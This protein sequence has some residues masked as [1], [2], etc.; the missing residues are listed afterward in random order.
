ME[1]AAAG[2]KPG[3]TRSVRWPA[4][5]TAWRVSEGDHVQMGQTLAQVRILGEAIDVPA[6]HAGLIELILVPA[7]ECLVPGHVLARLIAF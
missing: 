1:P 4:V 2:V 7:G 6:P 5:L 3:D